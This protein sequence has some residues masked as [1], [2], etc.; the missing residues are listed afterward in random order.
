MQKALLCSLY[1][2]LVIR[3][4]ERFL[5]KPRFTLEARSSSGIEGIVVAILVDRVGMQLDIVQLV[6]AHALS[7]LLKVGA[8]EC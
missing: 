3:F 8:E 6:R 5:R 7:R 4:S 2:P 1:I